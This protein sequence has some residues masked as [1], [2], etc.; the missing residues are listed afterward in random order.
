M[1]AGKVDCACLYKALSCLML[2]GDLF[3]VLILVIDS[4]REHQDLGGWIWGCFLA[5][6]K[7]MVD[8]SPCVAAQLEVYIVVIW[9]LSNI[10]VPQN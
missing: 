10:E 5:Y 8:G 1:S 9:D 4:D 6:L 2:N 3:W 7:E